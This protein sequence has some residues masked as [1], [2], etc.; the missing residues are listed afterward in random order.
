MVFSTIEIQIS[1]IVDSS[2]GF[3]KNST[4]KTNVSDNTKTVLNTYQTTPDPTT[5][6]KGEPLTADNKN[7]TTITN[8]NLT[9]KETNHLNIDEKALD[10]NKKA[11]D[12]ALPNN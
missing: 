8:T 1:M 10:S 6:A 4:L 9:S 5:T 12:K 3:F 2:D 11:I 7:K